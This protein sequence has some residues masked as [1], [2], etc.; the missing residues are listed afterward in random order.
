MPVPLRPNQCWS[1]DFLSDTFGACRKFRILAVNDDCCRENLALIVDISISGTRGA[2]EL[3]ALV[4][5]HGK[6]ACIVSDN[7]FEFTSKAILKWASDNGGEWH[8]IDPGKPSRTA[9]SSHSTA[10]CATN[11]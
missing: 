10:A 9:A 3:D 1:L 11:A 2:R 7:G 4:R 6:P 8:C 5:I